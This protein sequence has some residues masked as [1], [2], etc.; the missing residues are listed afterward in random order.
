[1]HFHLDFAGKL[2]AQVI[3]VHSRSPVDLGRIFA[4]EEANSQCFFLV[5]ILVVI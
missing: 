2:A 5:A 1:M 4:C 3:D